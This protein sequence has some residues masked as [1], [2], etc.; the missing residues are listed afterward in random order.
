[1]PEGRRMSAEDSAGPTV[2]GHTDWANRALDFELD[3]GAIQVT[4]ARVACPCCVYGHE[5][6][7]PGVPE[8]VEE[9]R[10]LASVRLFRAL[11]PR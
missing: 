3:H 11:L 9:R 8:T 2:E 6:F 5:P 7:G 1:M 10:L 4:G